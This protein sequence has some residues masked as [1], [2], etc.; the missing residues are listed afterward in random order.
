MDSETRHKINKL[1][2][3]ISSGSN[4]FSLEEMELYQ[5]YSKKIKIEINKIKES[6]NKH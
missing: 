5:N 2:V 6:S 3:K 1:A 4:N